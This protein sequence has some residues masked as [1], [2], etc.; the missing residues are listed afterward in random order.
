MEEQQ[1]QFYDIHVNAAL[2]IQKRMIDQVD[3]KEYVRQ[4]AT[5]IQYIDHLYIYNLTN[6]DLN[7]FYQMLKK[8][9][10]ISF[11]DCEDFGQVANYQMIYEQLLETQANFGMIMEQGYYFEENALLTLRRYLIENDYS[12]IAVATPMPL[13]GCEVL[14]RQAEKVRP[15][16]GCNFVGALLNLKLF[17]ELGGFKLEYY[18]TTFDY[19]YCIRARLKGYSILLFQNE[20][21]RNSNYYLIEKRILFFKLSTFDYDL[22]DVYYQTRN[23]FY[24]W[25]EYAALDAKYVKVDKKLYKAERHELKVRDPNYRDKFYMMEEARFDYV[26]GLKGKYKGGQKSEKN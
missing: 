25:D 21:L 24:L 5:Y 20:V 2:I 1:N 12:K 3:M 9:D 19:E 15:C 10:N 7:E 16:M 6:Q 17:Q 26:R 14:E 22:M 18:Q 4:I 11:T 13:R 23:R 8:Y